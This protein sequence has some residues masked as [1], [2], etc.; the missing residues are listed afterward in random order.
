LCVFF[1]FFF[2]LLLFVAVATAGMRYAKTKYLELEIQVQRR[3]GLRG[4]EQVT[5]IKVL[6]QYLVTHGSSMPSRRL[7]ECRCNGGSSVKADT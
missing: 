1:L 2:S 3:M 6:C 4:V 7:P 5:A